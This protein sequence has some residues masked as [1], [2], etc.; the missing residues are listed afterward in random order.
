MALRSLAYPVPLSSFTRYAG[1]GGGG[2]GGG[3]RGGGGGGRGLEGSG[4]LPL[5]QQFS[6]HQGIGGG[7]EALAL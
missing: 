3:G 2:G 6:L 1:G 4:T 5:T 7:S